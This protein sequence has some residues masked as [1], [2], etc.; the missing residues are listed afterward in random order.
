MT[1]S[2]KLAPASRPVATRERILDV[3]EQF[4]QTRGYNGFSY[5]DVAREIGIATASL[6]HHFPTKADL[7]AAVVDRY[8]ARVY[9]A[10]AS[11]DAAALDPPQALARY[12]DVYA[13]V[14][15]QDRMCLIGM[16]AAEYNTLP[17]PMQQTLR[18]YIGNNERWLMALLARGRA[19]GT[20]LPTGTDREA[21]LLLIGALEGTMLMSRLRGDKASF[22]ASVQQLLAHLQG[23]R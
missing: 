12:T 19:A 8:A 17:V 5:A 2:S 21:A 13:G 16:L 3:A 22:A 1:A 20:L 11:I 4:M 23:P 9:E 10:A 6:H 15:A 18:D 7:G 14:L